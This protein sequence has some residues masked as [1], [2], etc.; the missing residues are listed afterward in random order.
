MGERKISWFLEKLPTAP[1]TRVILC[2][3]DRPGLFATMVGVFTLNNMLVLAARIFTLKN[4]LAFDIYDVTNPPDP[5][6]EESTWEKIQGDIADALE[7]HLPLDE[8]IQQ[9]GKRVLSRNGRE[10]ATAVRVDIDNQISDFFSVVA[11]RGPS[12]LGL[13]YELAK[14]IT[15]LGLDIRFARFSRDHEKMTGDFYVRDSLGQK[16]QEAHEAERVTREI[17][18]LFP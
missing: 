4:G 3:T 8:R 12:R 13:L 7:G 14:K 17:R 5:Y 18:G 9:K 10:G 16:I 1:V 2:T 11:V 15:V 6:T